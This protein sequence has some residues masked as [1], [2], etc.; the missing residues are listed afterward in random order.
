MAAAVSPDGPERRPVLHAV[1][2]LLIYFAVE[3]VVHLIREG[4]RQAA[5]LSTQALTIVVCLG[6]CG[7]AA[8]RPLS[9]PLTGGVLMTLCGL[10]AVYDAER[11]A[12][13][14]TRVWPVYLAFVH[15]AQQVKLPKV[16]AYLV[17]ACAAF[18]TLLVELD[19]VVRF[20]LL[21]STGGELFM[22][23]DRRREE[24]CDCAAPPCGTSVG[25]FFPTACAV[26]AV[27]YI[28]LQSAVPTSGASTDGGAAQKDAEQLLR[29]IQLISDFRL[30][31]ADEHLQR[32]FAAHV[33]P[34]LLSS[35]SELIAKMYTYKPHLPQACLIFDDADSSASSASEQF[36][37]P[38][39]PRG[40]GRPP[41]VDVE[42]DSSSD[43]EGPSVISVPTPT[44]H[45]VRSP[46]Q[47]QFT[48]A[49]ESAPSTMPLD[50][51]M[52]SEASGPPKSPETV[53]LWGAGAGAGAGTDAVESTHASTDMLRRRVS[54]R[55]SLSDLKN[56]STG[57]LGLLNRDLV[58]THLSLV[59]VNL[60]GSLAMLKN[61]VVGF[62]LLHSELI[63]ASLDA[64]AGCKGVV[65]LFV[66]DRVFVSFNASRPCSAHVIHAMR[67]TK[68]FKKT[69]ESP[70]A[71]MI[72]TGKA[73]CGN[74]GCP[75]Y[76]RYS[77]LGKLPLTHHALLRFNKKWDIPV[78]C[79]EA[80]RVQAEAMFDIRVV[81]K[82]LILAR[83]GA[84][85]RDTHLYEVLIGDAEPEPE[86]G[87]ETD[88]EWMYTV[89]RVWSRY[90]EAG[91]M[92]LKNQANRASV[93]EHIQDSPRDVMEYMRK[94]LDS[95]FADATPIRVQ[96]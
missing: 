88:M 92:F 57:R 73:L 27:F 36:L 25:T 64:F 82:N 62:A 76:L 21:D 75:E 23:Y 69:F 44:N 42:S 13:G 9:V 83:A 79:T 48:A 5:F 94:Q 59:T 18:A 66:G 39:G 47:T 34:S 78:L 49:I 54:R 41:P 32:A 46:G 91:W 8:R 80:V 60:L 68:Q 38:P 28:C 81:L 20:G 7:Y 31:D 55:M 65:D 84:E 96:Y 74:L 53:N 11:A 29:I 6:V 22:S 14:A 89:D 95:G 71:I 87:Q 4:G 93:M 50:Q 86:P 19:L 15:I 30:D 58:R 63:Q 12:R 72:T 56:P 10:L 3:F 2:A 43:S 90:N 85:G 70:C 37:S 33:D 67:A 52:G 77:V 40:R 1:A 35:L 16:W 51:S 17:L 61:N 24:A 45:K 26:L